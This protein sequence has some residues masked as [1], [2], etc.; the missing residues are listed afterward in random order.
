VSRAYNARRKA[1]RKRARI[2]RDD[3]TAA[4][5]LH[6]RP[7]RALLP[8]LVIAGILATVGLLSSGGT[9][10]AID[11]KE[12]QQKVSTLLAGIPQRGATLGSAK[13]PLT[14]RVYADLECPT[15]KLFVEKHL[16]SLVDKWIRPG[17]VKLEYR[18]LQTDTYDERIFFDQEIAALAAGRQGKMW[19]YFLTFVYQ[20]GENFTPYA[21]K[22][23]LA[24]VASQ[25]PRLQRA[26]WL[27]D[28]EDLQLSR[29]VALGVHS[30]R[31][32]GFRSTP[33]FLIDFAESGVGRHA[34][35]GRRASLR[36]ELHSSLTDV[37][38]SLNEETT[39]DAPALGAFDS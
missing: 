27:S 29:Q 26:Q 31:V 13:A 2:E 28:R 22:E 37:V 15:V 34:V 35:H 21:T 39:R 1:K 17:T 8:A 19:D 24:D 12:I 38:R 33:S 9:S 18:S 11:K 32:K 30:G 10:S 7:L 25:I 6:P 20:Q 23:F 4:R 36:R 16:P 14:L 3:A 5:R